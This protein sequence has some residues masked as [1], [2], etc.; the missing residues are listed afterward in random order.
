LTMNRTAIMFTG[1]VANGLYT[2]AASLLLL[3]TKGQYK[4]WVQSSGILLVIAGL[5]SSIAC[6]A[7]SIFG[8]IASTT[9]LLPALVLWLLGI[10]V[11]SYLRSKQ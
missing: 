10:A 4:W 8:M 1:Y 5:W 11:D 7:N 3:A 6:L 2:L 9:L